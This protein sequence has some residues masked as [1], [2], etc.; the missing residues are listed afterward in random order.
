MKLA[1]MANQPHD[2]LRMLK[3]MRDSKEPTVGICMGDIGT[4]SRMLAG[5]L[6]RRGRLPRFI[7]NGC[8]LPGS[9]AS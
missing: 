9:S 5:G 4:P 7:T 6:V 3:L 2:N 8:W 1:T